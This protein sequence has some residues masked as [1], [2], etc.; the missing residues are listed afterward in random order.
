MCAMNNE[1]RQAFESICRKRFENDQKKF[2]TPENM[3]TYYWGTH[4]G[5]V[6]YDKN[7]ILGGE[8][9]TCFDISVLKKNN[10]YRMWFSWRRESSIGYCES[11]DGVHFSEPKVVL[12]AL[13]KSD[14]EGDEIN[15][16]SVL[17]VDGIY[18]MWYSGQMMPYLEGGTS[19]IGYAEST[20]GIHWNRVQATPVLSPEMSWEETSIMCPDVHYD[21]EKKCYKMWYSA[22]C[23][24]EPNAIGYAESPDGIHWKKYENNPIFTACPSCRWEAKKVAACQIIRQNG[25]YY[26]LYIGYHH[27][28]R[29]SI[30]IARSRDGITNWER[31]LQ[32]PIIAPTKGTWDQKSVYKPYALWDNDHWI[33]WYN[34]ADYDFSFFD[35]VHEQI[36]AAYLF[37]RSLWPEEE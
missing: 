9:G 3:A 18:K 21:A 15:R 22:G 26:M 19:H 34:G 4:A 25:W 37:K 32:N 7:P 17:Y 2:D 5:W 33:L 6:K 13:P 14:W 8:Y 10:L 35:C 24:H 12:S 16:P 29:G 11:L 31:S 30:G 1:Q 28:Q 27:E 20:D 23:N 36:G